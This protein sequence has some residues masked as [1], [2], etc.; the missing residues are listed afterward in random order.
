[1]TVAVGNLLGAQ[2]HCVYQLDAL[3]EMAAGEGTTSLP[4]EG[5]GFSTA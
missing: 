5:R 1:M 4:G 2:W 3:G